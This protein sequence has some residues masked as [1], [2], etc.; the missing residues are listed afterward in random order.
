MALGPFP[1]ASQ[2]GASSVPL[3]PPASTQL[4][5]KVQ[6]V[7]TVNCLLCCADC[8]SACLLSSCPQLLP[9]AQLKGVWQ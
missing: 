4:C 5:P 2:A 8:L 1:G 7:I 6:E 3:T 9:A